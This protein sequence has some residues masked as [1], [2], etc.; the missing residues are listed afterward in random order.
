MQYTIEETAGYLVYRVGRLLRYRAGQ[1]FKQEGLDISPEQWMLLLLVHERGEAMLSDLVEPVV[2]DHPN[3]TRMVTGLEKLGYL[4]RQRNPED[5]RSRL[6][7]LTPK[8]QVLVHDVLPNLIE[9][10]AA[11]FEG[12]DQTDVSRMISSLQVVLANLEA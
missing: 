5:K 2:G 6:V 10:K 3:V 9:A 7:S 8:A 12:L 4:E 11:Y 1:Y